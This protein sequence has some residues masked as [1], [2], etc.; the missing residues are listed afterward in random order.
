MIFLY[1]SWTYEDTQGLKM[2]VICLLIYFFR[3]SSPFMN[4]VWNILKIVLI[5][6]L[7]IT[8]AGIALRWFKK[9]F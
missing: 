8:T 4:N 6:I 2:L 7:I 1:D 9:F 3:N 5:I